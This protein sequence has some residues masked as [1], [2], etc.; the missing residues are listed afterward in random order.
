[1]CIYYRLD[2]HYFI[3]QIY[4]QVVGAGETDIIKWLHKYMWNN[5]CD[6]GL[7]VVKVTDDIVRK[8]FPEEMRFESKP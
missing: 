5:I 6:R 8:G 1:M 3:Q 2:I 4:K 7:T